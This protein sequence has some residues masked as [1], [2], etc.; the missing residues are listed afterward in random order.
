MFK[1]GKRLFTDLKLRNGILMDGMQN[2]S[3]F[4]EL[5]WV[6]SKSPANRTWTG[7]LFLPPQTLTRKVPCQRKHNEHCDHAE[8]DH[9]DEDVCH[10]VVDCPPRE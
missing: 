5:H 9:D 1:Q 7:R 8:D 2:P 6:L 3:G 10:D 4:L